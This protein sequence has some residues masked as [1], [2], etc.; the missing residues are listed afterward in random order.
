MRKEEENMKSKI[1]ILMTICVTLLSTPILTYAKDNT[2]G[3]GEPYIKMEKDDYSDS[4]S[5]SMVCDDIP[6]PVINEDGSFEVKINSIGYVLTSDKFKVSDTS[7]KITL[8]AGAGSEKGSEYYVTLYKD[9]VFPSKVKTITYYTG[10]VYEYTFK[11][12]S[13]SSKYFLEIDSN[14][15]TLN[16]NGTISNYVHIN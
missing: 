5:A 8:D 2:L 4:D 12:L 13:T 15:T 7:C 11:N 1:G 3:F 14:R 9:G 10:G 16:C 6:M